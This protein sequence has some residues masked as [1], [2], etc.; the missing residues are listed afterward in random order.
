LVNL[1]QTN[2]DY[3]PG[4]IKLAEVLN[5]TG[6]KK[7]AL[8]R[9]EQALA[10]EPDNAAAKAMRDQINGVTTQPST[11]STTQST[12]QPATLPAPP[13]PESTTAP[14]TGGND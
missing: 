7:E 4:Y 10:L 8:E 11:Q 2:P 13:T 3:V 12:T 6:Y 9:I 5:M 14:I 1:V